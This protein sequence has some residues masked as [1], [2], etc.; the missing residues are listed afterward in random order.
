M[1]TTDPANTASQLPLI[2]GV[3]ISTQCESQ[4]KVQKTLD[5]LRQLHDTLNAQLYANPSQRPAISSPSDAADLFKP[6]LAF[7]DHEELWV[8][9]LDTRNR[10]KTMVA[11]YRGSVNS[12]QVRVAEVFK[13]A[14]IENSPSIVIAHNHPSGDSSPSP[15]DLTITRSIIMAGKLLDISLLDHIVIS[16]NGF[17]SMKEKGLGFS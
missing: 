5:K 6:F 8:A 1:V 9:V 14:I 2:G 3:S 11:L 7:L 16:S 15:D 10:L 17:V 12:S 13:Q 4:K